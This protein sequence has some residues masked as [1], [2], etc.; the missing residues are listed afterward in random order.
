[1]PPGRFTVSGLLSEVDAPGEYFFNGATRMLY[2]F[3]PQSTVHPGGGGR[4]GAADPRLSF[5][6]GP[7]FATLDGSS[8]LTIRDLTLS[9]LAGTAVTISGGERNTLGGCTIKNSAGGVNLAGGY[10]NAVR[11]NDV[12][13]VGSHI[14]SSGNTADGLHNLRP[15]NNLISNNHMTQ[16]LLTM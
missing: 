12:Y 11:G 14:T 6:S 1:M 10:N 13:D 2:I 9:G 16:V 7:A 4:S 3:P 8:W 5:W 15:T